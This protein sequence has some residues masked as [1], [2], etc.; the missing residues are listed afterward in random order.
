[1]SDLS[2]LAQRVATLEQ[3]FGT[4]NLGEWSNDQDVPWWL[5]RVINPASSEVHAAV[6]S[7]VQLM[8]QTKLTAQGGSS[9]GAA[10]FSAD[11]V[12]DWCGTKVPHHIPPR[13]HWS[14]YLSAIA[15]LADT[16]SADSALR[17]AAFDLGR[18]LLDR[19]RDRTT[20]TK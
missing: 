9:D 10:R 19:A 14:V 2:L 18:R 6:V 12:D 4:V 16:Y 8:A 17:A 3:M 20:Q 13:P 1:M 5:A 11:I 15:R 7:A